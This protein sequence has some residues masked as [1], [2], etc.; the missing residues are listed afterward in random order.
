MASNS[1][2]VSFASFSSSCSLVTASLFV[3]GTVSKVRTFSFAAVRRALVSEIVR[4]AAKRF[5]SRTS[6]FSFLEVSLGEGT[7]GGK[8]GE[9]EK[10]VRGEEREGREWK[11]EGD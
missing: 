10:R 11:F 4:F 8:G 3:G 9:I 2:L 1:D 5:P 7:G 6:Y